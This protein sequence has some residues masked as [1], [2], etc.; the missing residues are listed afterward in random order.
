MERL[1]YGEHV[2]RELC[3]IQLRT[4]FTQFLR[5]PHRTLDNIDPFLLDL[6]EEKPQYARSVVEFR[7][8]G[9]EQTA[10]RQFL[11][12]GPFQPFVE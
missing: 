8:C 1:K 10:T 2:E 4:E 7:C 11:R 3:H 5:F 6:I 9:D 12:C